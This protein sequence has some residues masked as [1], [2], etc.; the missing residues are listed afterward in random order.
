M[1]ISEAGGRARRWLD[2]NLF[3][4]SPPPPALTRRRVL[5][6]AAIAL[7]S[8]AIL[9]AR[10]WSSVPLDSIWAEDG[11]TWLNDAINRDFLDAL[12]TPYNGYI[13][14]IGRLVAE[15]VSY[16]P[17]EWFAAS[18]AI[19]GAAI[20]TGCAFIVWRA[21]AAHVENPYLRAT[22]ATLIVLLPVVGWETL[23]NVTNAIWFMLFASFW[24]LLWRPDTVARAGASGG[25]LFLTAISTAGVIFLLPLWLLRLIAA[26]DR[27]DVIMVVSFAVGVVVMLGLSWSDRNLTSEDGTL[28]ATLAPHWDWNLMAAYVQRV[29]GGA[30]T[31]QSITGHLWEELGAAF[32]IVLAGAL[33]LLVGSL[34]ARGSGRSRVIVILAVAIS[35]S[36]F[37]V[38]GYERWYSGAFELFWPHETSNAKTA[39]YVVVPTLLLLSVIILRLDQRPRSASGRS[40]RIVQAGAVLSL[41]VIS[42]SSFGVGNADLRGNRTWSGQLD[43][44]RVKCTQPGASSVEV[45]VEPP[46]FNAFH[47]TVPCARLDQ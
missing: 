10:M 9:L 4:E 45:P 23:D 37:L 1:R 13:Q 46:I 8:M 38:A 24:V 40:W 26:R 34:L 21:S 31:G 22:L 18:M 41:F 29:V 36:L 11:S 28:Q 5:V 16:L 47:V 17:V 39:R 14:T 32:L 3:P 33:L 35:L 25:F 27:R 6:I 42:L 44:S 15:P 12:S 43:A 20:V 30:V 2:G 7:A 19:A